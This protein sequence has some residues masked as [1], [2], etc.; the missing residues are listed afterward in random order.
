MLIAESASP[1]EY[2][3][4]VAI[5]VSPTHPVV[6]KLVPGKAVAGFVINHFIKT[7]YFGIL[8]LKSVYTGSEVLIFTRR[9]T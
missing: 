7:I 4:S 1:I 5:S 8:L 6:E 9:S 3:Q 2:H